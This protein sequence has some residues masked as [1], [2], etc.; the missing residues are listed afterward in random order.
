MDLS[1]TSG[2]IPADLLS[3]KKLA[4]LFDSG[5][6][7]EGLKEMSRETLEYASVEQNNAALVDSV[8]K[9]LKETEPEKANIE[10]AARVVEV[11]RRI[12]KNILEEA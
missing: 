8:L 2:Q 3:G 10:Y 1:Q 12:A 5:R 7:R 11:M 4:S 6:L 9:S